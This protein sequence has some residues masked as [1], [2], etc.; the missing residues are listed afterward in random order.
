MSQ[1]DRHDDRD[2][3]DLATQLNSPRPRTSGWRLPLLALGRIAT[4]AVLAPPR[5]GLRTWARLNPM[6]Q[7]VGGFGLYA[8]VGTM[9]LCL[10]FAQTGSGAI[11][12]HAFNAVSAVSTTGLTTISVADSYTRFGQVVLL[13]LFQVGGIGFMTLASIVLLARG[14]ALPNEHVEVLKVGFAVPHYFVMQ[15]FIVQVV[16]FTAACETLGA[17]VLWWR[18]A[19]AGI[20][21]PL[22]SAI[23]H[24]VS[25][26]ATAGFS[27]HNDSL[28]RFSSDWMVNLT[29]GS[30]SYLG[31]IGYIVVQDVWYSLKHREAMVTFTS[32]VILVM[33][34]AVFVAG[35]AIL[36]LGEPSIRALPVGDR[37]LAS[38]FQTMTASSTAGFNTIP[39]GGMSAAG[40]VVVMLAMLI[41][42]SPAGTGGGIKTT[43]VSA[44]VGNLVSVLRRRDR[45]I[46]LGREIP[47][48]RV[49][50][51]FAASS[52]Y[53]IGL[54]VGVLVLCLSESQEFL[55][56]VFEAA[57][58]IGTVGL[59]MGITGELSTPGKLAV[60]ALMFAG[61]CGPITI[62]LAL[63]RAEERPPEAWGDDLAI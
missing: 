57:S 37:L 4:W 52:L 12:D 20:D 39:I 58:A 30:L 50:F 44:I 6:Q 48:V 59:S 5:V 17:L 14:R 40:L 33:T 26:F 63:L 46:W 24:S 60:M 11:V 61:R 3:T 56:I 10:P 9:L 18:F 62:G 43:S 49:L 32:K 13:L 15:H 41:G 23:F 35:T 1:Q 7:F 31:A 53:L 54:C 45:V 34:A 38:A 51:A 55:P 8:L 36:F 27:L 25:A 2:S 47:L 29:I 21:A 42:A 22:W 16:V 19:E 28:E